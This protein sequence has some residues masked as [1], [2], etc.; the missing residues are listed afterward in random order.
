VSELK[1]FEQWA[2]EARGE[3]PPEVDV[4]ARVM[5]TIRDAEPEPA[6]DGLLWAVS[7]TSLAAAVVASVLA[8]Y[9]WQ[10]A[11]DPAIAWLGQAPVVLP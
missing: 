4:A 6:V 11:T 3:D 5:R 8:L 1:R 7:A 9:A 2:A 10:A